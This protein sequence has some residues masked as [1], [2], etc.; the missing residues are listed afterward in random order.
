MLEIIDNYF[1]PDSVNEDCYFSSYAKLNKPSFEEAQT[2]SVETVFCDKSFGIHKPWYFLPD[3]QIKIISKH[4]PDIYLLKDLYVNFR[5]TEPYD[6][7]ENI[8]YIFPL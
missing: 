2:F 3:E 7:I 1:L 5:N 4:I 8:D 6:H